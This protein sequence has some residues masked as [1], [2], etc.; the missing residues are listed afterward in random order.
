MVDPENSP[1]FDEKVW[2]DDSKCVDSVDLKDGKVKY[3]VVPNTS[4]HCHKNMCTMKN[5]KGECPQICDILKVLDQK[6]KQV[7]RLSLSLKVKT[8]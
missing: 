8:K 2:T 6:K 5:D 3:K 7:K 1:Q 4:S